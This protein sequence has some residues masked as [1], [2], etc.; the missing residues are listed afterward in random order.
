MTRLAWLTDIHLDF[1]TLNQLSIFC[2]KIKSKII[3]GYLFGGD[4]SVAPVLIMHLKILADMLQKPIYFVLGNHDY[5]NGSIRQ[6]RS[7][8]SIA[9]RANEYLHWLPDEGVIEISERAALIGHGCWA[10]GRLGNAEN[11]Q[12]LLNDYVL[13]N[14]FVNLSTSERFR[15]LNRLGDEAAVKVEK[16]LLKAITSFDKII[17]LT[18]VPP[19]KESSWYNAHIS[20]D[21]F[22]PHF[23]CFA[24]GQKLLE[25]MKKFPDKTLTVLCGHTH[26]KGQAHISENILVKTGGATYRKPEIQEI[27]ELE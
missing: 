26:G 23:S 12:V 14:E 7:D 5:Y 1:L 18:H 21:E 20:D 24:V 15:L 27:I 3:D 17:L 22:L 11:S 13:I 2:E 9:C 16:L 4:I 10:D 25:I 8:I 6:I 19:F